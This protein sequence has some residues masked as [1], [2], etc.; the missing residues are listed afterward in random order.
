MGLAVQIPIELPAAPPGAPGAAPSRFDGTGAPFEEALKAAVGGTAT[1]SGPGGKPTAGKNP[2]AAAQPPA[3]AGTADGLAG[4]ATAEKLASELAGALALAALVPPAVASV[5][6]PGANEAGLATAATKTPVT[7]PGLSLSPEAPSAPLSPTAVPA[8]AG[9]TGETLPTA[10]P[11]VTTAAELRKSDMLEPATAPR[12]DTEATAPATAAGLPSLHES[13]G[14]APG[15]EPPPQPPAP[16]PLLQRHSEALS[17]PSAATTSATPSAFR[18]VRIDGN[19]TEQGPG[20]DAG[21]QDKQENASGPAVRTLTFSA[22]G[23]S[24]QGAVPAGTINASPSTATNIA[25]PTPPSPTPIPQPVIQVAQTV[26][27][28]VNKG[29]GEARIHLHP[30]ELGEVLIRVRTDGDKVHLDVHADRLD[31]QQLLRDHTTDLSSLLGNRGLTLADVNVGFGGQSAGNTGRDP[32]PAPANNPQTGS[33]EFA[34][35]MGAGDPAAAGLHNRLQS[36]YNPD[37]ALSYRI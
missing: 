31:A 30:A 24:L 29:G 13:T 17:P 25:A 15:A 20:S 3:E 21:K 34:A 28:Q 32:H 2:D 14:P 22:E 33:G 12:S 23:P 36:A 5:A 16:G 35:L 27:D 7:L 37:G 18:V 4:D 1:G 19:A 9:P 10:I 26:I 6:A 8:P 11:V